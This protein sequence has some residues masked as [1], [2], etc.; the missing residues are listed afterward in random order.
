MTDTANM[1][2]VH[3]TNLLSDAAFINGKTYDA[4]RENGKVFVKCEIGM[5]I[6]IQIGSGLD[7]K[8]VWVYNGENGTYHFTKN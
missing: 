7:G 5:N 1:K 4:F 3:A 2:C 6:Q 8:S